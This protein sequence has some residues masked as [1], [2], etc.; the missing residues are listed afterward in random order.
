LSRVPPIRIR[1]CND[2]PLRPDREFV[3]YWMTAFRRTNWNFALDRAA[4]WARELGK[5]ILILE[6]LRCGYR[7]ASDRFHRFVMDGM[8]EKNEELARSGV[9]YYPYVERSAGAGKGL[10]SA[11]AARACVVVTDDYPAFFIPHMLRSAARQ[12]PVRL[13]AV[14]SNGLFPMRA[15][16]RGFT[17]A[18]SFRRFLQKNL[19]AQLGAFPEKNPLARLALPKLKSLPKN[20]ANQWKPASTS[21]LRDPAFLARLPIDH[22]VGAAPAQG[23]EEAARKA[24]RKFLKD[25]LDDYAADRNQPEKEGT[26]NLSQYLHFGQIS[27]HQVFW[28]L[29]R[30]EKWTDAKI[31]LRTT[32]SRLGWWGMRQAAEEFLDQLITWRE[33]GFQEVRRAG[34]DQ[35]AALPE[36]A[37]KTLAKHARDER[38]YVYTLDEFAGGRT[39]DSLWNAAQRQLSQ[40][41]RMHN[42]LRMLWGKKILEWSRNPEEALAIMIEL[43]NRYALD[44]R[45]P[46]SYSGI[47]WCLGRYD[48]PWGPERP[49]FGTV[50]YM[51]SANTARKVKVKDYLKRFGV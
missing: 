40:E 34:Y 7:W 2:A 5:P 31:A 6:A 27:A 41:G 51:S 23:G 22:R 45:D 39:H 10:I 11:A 28:E 17:T 38:V 25:R 49:I 30:R 48:H 13:E 29:V 18:F 26:S 1:T 3:L 50:R 9:S 43:N 46:N 4:E 47:F 12:S 44:G 14:D 33:L 20:L 8:A 36:W 24:L 21:E 19:P 15:A 32:G 35:Y 37:R 16:D 42:Y